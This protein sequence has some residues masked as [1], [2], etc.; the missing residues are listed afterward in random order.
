VGKQSLVW[1]EGRA[2]QLVWK[3]AAAVKTHATGRVVA[4]VVVVI[5]AAVVI[6]VAASTAAAGPSSPVAAAVAAIS[7]GVA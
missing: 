7:V 5:G 2:A 6:A 4:V 1:A 3:D